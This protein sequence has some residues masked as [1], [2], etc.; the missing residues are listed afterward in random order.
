MI[1]FSIIVDKICILPEKTR[2]KYIKTVKKFTVSFSGCMQIEPDLLR[3][4][5]GIYFMIIY[6][7]YNILS[8]KECI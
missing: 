3:R 2:L 6:A 5:V 7:N 1:V 4:L 8:N